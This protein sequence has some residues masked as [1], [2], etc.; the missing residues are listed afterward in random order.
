MGLLSDIAETILRLVPDDSS[1]RRSYAAIDKTRAGIDSIAKAAKEAGLGAT[2]MGDDVVAGTEKATVAALKL[3]DAYAEVK[4]AAAEAAK[5][6]QDAQDIEAAFKRIADSIE[7]VGNAKEKV[8][9]GGGVGSAFGRIGGVGS[10]ALGAVGLGEVGNALNNFGDVAEVGEVADAVKD[11]VKN[12]APLQ[13][14]ATGLAPVLGTTGAA[15]ASLGIAIA[16]IAIAIGTLILA[17]KSFE[18][19]IKKIGELQR[20]QFA[21][22]DAQVNRQLATRQK[23][24]NQTREALQAEATNIQFELDLRQKQLEN[25]QTAKAAIEAQYTA[26]GSSFNIGERA[27]LGTRGQEA[28]TEVERLTKVVGDLTSQLGATYDATYSQVQAEKDLAAARNQAGLDALEQLQTNEQLLSRLR[29]MGANATSEQVESRLES[30]NREILTLDQYGKAAYELSQTLEQGSEAYNAADKQAHQY[31]EQ[32]VT[33][34]TEQEALTT[35]ILPVIQAREAEAAALEYQQKQLEETAAAVKKYNDDIDNLTTKLD[36]SRAK[37]VQTLDDILAKAEESAIAAVKKLMAARAELN[38]KEIRDDQKAERDAAN[39]HLDLGIKEAQQEADIY[40]GYRRKLRDL[41]KAANEESFDL[42]LNR[43]FSGLFKLDRNTENKKQDAAQE[44]RDAIEDAREGKQRQLEDLQRGL[45]QERQERQIALQQNIADAVAAY[46]Q[47]HAEIDLQ[48][49]DSETKAR[50]AQ[51]RE[52]EILQQQVNAR[53]Q[54]LQSELILTQKSEAERAAI[55]AQYQAQLLAQAQA[56]FNAITNVGGGGKIKPTA[57]AFG[58][59]LGA[60]MASTV[61]ELPGQQ[62]SY[63]SGGSSVMLP[64]GKG[65]FIPFQSGNVNPN[66]G[67][68]GGDT[69]N[70][71]QT[72]TGGANAEVIAEIAARKA[73]QAIKAVAGL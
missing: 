24:A 29:E 9:S 42:I 32:I 34:Q 11:V 60:F 64:Q 43:D 71:N 4:K 19:S 65:L 10:R 22:V 44:E 50:A 57:S 54:A 20:Q 70:V 40:K 58:N 47:E 35:S 5:T 72:I 33:L 25:A 73:M 16:P 30:I 1:F 62:E 49:K 23:A 67:G 13:K 6:A 26:L 36:D 52:Q 51:K 31:A 12:I 21:D 48:R 17:F 38:Q 37:L 66:P 28:A 7:D 14:I 53:A 63:N 15:F 8:T 39:Q 59:S 55:I 46:Q 2:Q 27:A 41:E 68:A 3:K 18:V 56:F 61:N 69:Y 45:E